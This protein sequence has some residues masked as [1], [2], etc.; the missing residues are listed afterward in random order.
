MDVQHFR[1]GDPFYSAE[2][3]WAEQPKEADSWFV[4]ATARLEPLQLC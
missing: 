3:L 2:Q 4:K 1:E